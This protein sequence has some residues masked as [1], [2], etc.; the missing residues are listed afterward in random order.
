MRNLVVAAMVMSV[1][2]LALADPVPIETGKDE[3]IHIDQKIVR[4][5]PPKLLD[6]RLA[7]PPYNE[8]I[9]TSNAWV[10]SYVWLDIDET[11]AVQ[12]VKFI[13]RPHH[14]LDQTAIDWALARRFSPAMNQFGHPVS[15]LVHYEMEWPSYD[16]LIDLKHSV[17]R[18]PTNAD[19][20]GVDM[21]GE[22][23]LSKMPPCAKDA[24]WEFDSLKTHISRDC[25][26]PDLSHANA[27]EP[28][29]PRKKEH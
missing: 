27:A 15:S 4:P 6:D 3:E 24:S 10:V 26:K 22:A 25:S 19:M 18:L 20:A 12:R 23:Y 5:Q 8:D 29:Y 14:G 2:S 13:K 16:W 9:R 11:G 1:G 21:A 28:W 7:I 17:R